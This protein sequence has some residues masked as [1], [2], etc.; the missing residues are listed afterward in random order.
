MKSFGGLILPDTSVNEDILTNSWHHYSLPGGFFDRNRS[1]GS[2]HEEHS[3]TSE[4]IIDSIE[5]ASEPT[6]QRMKRGVGNEF[7]KISGPRGKKAR[8]FSPTTAEITRENKAIQDKSKESPTRVFQE[9]FESKHH[10]DK[11]LET[12]MELHR[13]PVSDCSFPADDESFPKTDEEYRQRVRQVFDAIC[14]W[15][16][17]LEWRTVLPKGEENRISAEFSQDRPERRQGESMD[18]PPA[19]FMPT[20]AELVK[21]LPP[22]EDQQRRVLRQIPNDQTIEWISWGIVGAAIKSQQGNTQVPYWCVSEG[23]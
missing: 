5:N 13:K 14:D 8:K 23:G 20:E 3:S 18:D 19:D 11:S 7:N 6:A 22:V 17:I 1:V 21:M 15:S 9:L 12:I 4:T 10:A 2:G 16:Y